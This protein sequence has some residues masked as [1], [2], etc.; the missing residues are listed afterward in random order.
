[1]LSSQ[2]TH[3]ELL[4]AIRHLSYDTSLPNHVFVSATTFS[5]KATSIHMLFN[6]ECGEQQ[7]IYFGL[8][9]LIDVTSTHTRSLNVSMESS[10]HQ[11]V[12][13]Y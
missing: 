2:C 8:V 11:C 5:S 10:R 7:A 6:M 9:A 12:W 13:P 4:R 1:M 3:G